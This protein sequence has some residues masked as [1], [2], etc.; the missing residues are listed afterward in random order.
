MPDKGKEHMSSEVG[1]LP[2]NNE[3]TKKPLKAL[4]SRI[5]KRGKKT[6]CFGGRSDRRDGLLAQHS[7]HKKPGRAGQALTTD[8]GT[9][10]RIL[11]KMNQND[12]N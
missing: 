5:S 11:N 3:N 8:L 7:S 10:V 1:D 2:L 12:L 6:P 9:G 4:S